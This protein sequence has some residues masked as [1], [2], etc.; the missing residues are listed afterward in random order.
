MRVS[1]TDL[2]ALRYFKQSEYGD[3]EQLLAQLRGKAEPSEAMKVGRA[4]HGALERMPAGAFETTQSEG[5]TFYFDEIEADL[6]LPDVREIKA[7][8][9]YLIRGVNVTLVGKVDAVDGLIV[10]DHKLTARYDADRYFDSIQ[11]RA[12]LSMFMAKKFVYNVFIANVNGLDVYVRD[13]QQLPLYSYP[14]IDQ[15]VHRALVDFV[16]FCKQYLPERITNGN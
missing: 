6:W 12:Y 1:V 8:C 16:E 11:W 10:C 7:E 2:D 14:T 15:D 13:F 9:E 3:L 5:Y 4:F